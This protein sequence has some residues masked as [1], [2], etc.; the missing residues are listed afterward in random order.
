MKRRYKAL[1]AIVVPTIV[2]AIW[3]NVHPISYKYVIGYVVAVALMFKSSIISLWLVS[4]LKLLH[5]I[6]GLT[7]IQAI[8]LATKRWF[9]DNMFSKW[10]ERNVISHLKKPFIEFIQYYKSI[11]FKRKLKNII[12]IFIPILFGVW[13]MYVTDTFMSIALFVEL[14]AIIIGFFKLLWVVIAKFFIWLTNSWF[15]PIVE[16]FALSY[17]LDII[18]KYLGPNNVVSRFFNY[19]GDKLNN[20]FEYIGL[21]NK[22]IFDP[23]I[24]K[25]VSKRSKNLSKKLSDF[26]R[27][28]KIKDEYKYF[29]E[30]YNKILKGHINLYYYYPGMENEFDKKKLYSLINKKTADNIDIIAY[31]SRDGRGELIEEGYPNDF[32]HDIFLL[33]GIA[34]NKDYGVKIQNDD[35]IDFTDFWVLNTSSHPVKISSHSKVIK[36]DIIDGNS[37]K[38]IKTKEHIDFNKKDLFFEY[39]GKIVYPVEI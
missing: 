17:I 9:L 12:L 21:F 10:L 34:S 30:F 19:I 23:L 18:E 5:F 25:R 3:S 22:K 8:L 15:S 14:K 27:E 1:I 36:D 16:V 37:I 32:Y 38:L 31:V 13:V 2:L 33:K 20:F 35:K 6:K 29:D 11:N 28:K 7:L 24:N 26:L 39:N 4:K